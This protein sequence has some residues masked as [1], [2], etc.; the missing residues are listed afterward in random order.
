MGLCALVKVS[1]L[2][3]LS[4]VMTGVCELLDKIS[5]STSNIWTSYIQK[6]YIRASGNVVTANEGA[7]NSE[8]YAGKKV[9]F[10]GEPGLCRGGKIVANDDVIIN[11]LGSPGGSS[12][13]VEVPENGRIKA[14]QVYANVLIKIGE[15]RYKF[16]D[17]YGR[18]NARLD[19]DGQIRL[20]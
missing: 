4:A 17:N 15:R 5:D 13:E 7:Y 10:K 14:N 2:G 12:L 1:E 18:I 19:E 6:S 20:H 8:I 3:E 16:A 9:I 11:E